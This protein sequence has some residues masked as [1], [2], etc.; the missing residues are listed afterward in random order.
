M[1]RSNLL[2][3]RNEKLRLFGL[4][5][6]REIAVTLAFAA[7]M[8]ACA[9]AVTFGLESLAVAQ[10]QRDVD[11]A[12]ATLAAHAP[13]R[14]RAQALALDVARYQEFARELAIVSASGPERADDVV[15]VGNAMPPRVW[16]DSLVSHAD[17][18]ELTGTSATLDAMGTALAALDAA[19][20]ASSAT[21]VRLEPLQSDARAIRFAARLDAR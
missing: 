14:A 18:V 21:L 15:R 13:F 10:L 3:P 20:P 11:A 19:L 12:N 4:G 9:A 2:P 7:T 16:L 8:I 17:H 5:V 6:E 1:I